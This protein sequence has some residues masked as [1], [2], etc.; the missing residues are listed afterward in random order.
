[1]SRARV[2]T[3]AWVLIYGGLLAFSLGWFTENHSVGLGWTLMVGGAAAVAAGIVMI[4]VRS[5]MSSAAPPDPQRED[6]SP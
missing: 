3:L 5:R 1:M 4:V 6:P 2:E